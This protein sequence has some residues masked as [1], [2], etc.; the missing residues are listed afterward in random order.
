M[1]SRILRAIA[2]CWHYW[3][4]RWVQFDVY[5]DERGKVVRVSN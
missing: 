5:F 4:N 3:R 2:L 1:P